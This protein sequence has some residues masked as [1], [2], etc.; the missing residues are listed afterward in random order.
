MRIRLS[1]PAILA[2]L[3]AMSLTTLAPAG[4]NGQV[5][6]HLILKKNGYINKM[7]FLTGDPIKLVRVGSKLTEEAIIQGIG[8]DFILFSGQELPL[9]QISMV[10]K[11]RTSFNFVASGKALL[12]A[13]PGYLLIGVVNALF[14]GISPLPTANNLIVAGSLLAA[15]IVLPVFQI[16]RFPI[17]KTFT[18]KIV[19]SDP[20]LNK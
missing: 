13:A 6:N 15:G 7:H 11:Y 14:Q 10:V 3:L 5:E 8:E 20:W 12:V 16:R 2:A 17:G 18:L 1:L 9:N 19:Q 4:A